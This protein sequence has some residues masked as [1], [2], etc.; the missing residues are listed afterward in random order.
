MGRKPKKSRHP[1]STHYI[2]LSL[3][4]SEKN[5]LIDAANEQGMPLGEFLRWVIWEYVKSGKTLPP[6]PASRPKPTPDD[7][8]RAYLAGEKL[9]M[10]CGKEICKM[11]IVKFGGG[12]YCDICGLRVF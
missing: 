6:A 8:L 10:P 11:E 4:G 12:E 9:L 1:N 3:K 2:T 5:F 7:A